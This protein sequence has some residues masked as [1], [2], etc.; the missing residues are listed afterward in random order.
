M[1]HA[2]LTKISKSVE[3]P[4]DILWNFTKFLVDRDGNAVK[5]FDPTVEPAKIDSQIAELI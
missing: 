1:T 5:R 3:K 4:G 2:M